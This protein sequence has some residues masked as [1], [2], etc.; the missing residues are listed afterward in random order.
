MNQLPIFRDVTVYDEEEPCP[1]LEGRL[2]RLPLRI[3]G[4][5]VSPRQTDTRLADGQRRTGEFVYTTCCLNCSACEPIRIPVHEFRFSR[6]HR[7]TVRRNRELLTP[8]IG[9]VVVDRVRVELFNRHRRL[10]DLGRR[11]CNIDC[12]E[13]AWAFQR[14][15]FDTFELSWSLGEKLACVAICDQGATS[16]SAVY[17][18]YDPGLAPLSLG[19]WSILQQIEYC[20]QTCRDYLY[21]GFYISQSPNMSYKAR[22][23]PHQRLIDG[24]WEA[25]VARVAD[26]VLDSRI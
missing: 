16:V 1:Y 26:P 9:P 25:F 5:Q 10:R 14:S 18:Y 12:E 21:L 20:R 13:Y 4:N 11:E 23:L 15:C 19:T 6:T 17:T 7:R 24:Q 22:F 8:Y 2:A 3:P